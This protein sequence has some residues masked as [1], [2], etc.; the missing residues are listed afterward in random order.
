MLAG[1]P[2]NDAIIQLSHGGSDAPEALLQQFA[3]QQG[4]Q[5][6]NSQRT[7]I[8]GLPAATAEFQAQDQQGNTLAG[9]VTYVRY[10]TGTYQLLA[11]ATGA[12]YGSYA[13]LFNQSMQSFAQLTDQ[14]ALN[15]QPMHLS[16]VRLPRAMTVEEFYRQYPSSVK[17][18]LI[19]A[20]NG[21]NPGETMPAGKMA[22]RV[23]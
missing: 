3:Q 4:I 20:I 23:Q 10:G 7:T 11:Y 2:Q 9:R 19:A 16:L 1:S 5:T 21:M 22:K 12:R 15:K 17:V 8:N 13:S 14:T 6:G 18:E